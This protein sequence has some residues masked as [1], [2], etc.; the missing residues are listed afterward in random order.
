MSEQ[1][2]VSIIIISYNT[3]ELLRNC[4]K[5]ILENHPQF[6]F[7]ILVVDNASTDES[8]EMVAAE[9]QSV[10]LIKNQNNV[11]FARA[12]NQGIK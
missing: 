1:P 7:D 5:S 8:S 10:R 9:F 3:R 2:V 11:G 6:P 12:N 4:L